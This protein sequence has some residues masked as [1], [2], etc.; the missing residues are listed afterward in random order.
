MKKVYRLY[1]EMG[2][3]LRN[4]SPKRRVKAKLRDGR[5]DAVMSN[6]VWAMDF[7]HKPHPLK[8]CFS[9]PEPF[10]CPSSII[11]HMIKI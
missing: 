10:F 8:I 5:T 6:D 4:K 3:Q 1:K 9:N 7:A 11:I 2:L